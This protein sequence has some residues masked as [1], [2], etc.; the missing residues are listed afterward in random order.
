[1]TSSA[2][3]LAFITQERTTGEETSF[4]DRCSPL[5]IQIRS[6]RYDPFSSPSSSVPLCRS[7]LPGRWRGRAP[8]SSWGEPGPGRRRQTRECCP[9]QARRASPCGG[10][11]SAESRRTRYVSEGQAEEDVAVGT[12][13]CIEASTLEVFTNIRPPSGARKVLRYPP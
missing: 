1:M 6:V 7:H 8:A 5:K 10:P 3:S 2:S 11:G 12:T 9:Q 4:H 13:L